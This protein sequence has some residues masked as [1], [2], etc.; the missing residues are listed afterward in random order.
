MNLLL[1]AVIIILIFRLTPA[2]TVPPLKYRI[3]KESERNVENTDQ[4]KN[5]ENKL[6]KLNDSIYK[7]PS[8]RYDSDISIEYTLANRRSRRTYTNQALN[9]KEISQILWA[10][11]GITKSYDEPEFLRGGLKTSPSAGARY[12]L[13]IYLLSG[14]ISDLP[15]GLYKYFPIGHKLKKIHSQD[16]RPELA[17]VAL[18]QIMLEE[19]PADL[20]YTAVFDRT[21]SKYGERGKKRYVPMEIGH[22]A[23][24]VYLQ[25]VAL[26]LGTCAVGAFE[27]NK[28]KQLLDLPAAEEPMYIMP[29]G[30]YKKID[31]VKEQ[32]N[33]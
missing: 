6:T 10:A 15:T 9:A 25:T 17:Q 4:S 24:N 2:T 14:N 12:P 13:D 11:Y 21:T 28:V 27:D 26:G 7:L 16:L 23:E 19:A 20:V 30:Y 1:I 33:K 22:S 3:N 18:D 5:E 32:L 31:E 29:V 8:P